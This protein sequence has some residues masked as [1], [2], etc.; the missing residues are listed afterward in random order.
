MMFIKSLLRRFKP[1]VR[2][3]ILALTLGFLVHTLRLNWQQVLT[4]RFTTNAIASLITATGMTLLAHIWSGWVWYWIMQLLNAPVAGA[5]SVITYLKTNLAKYLPGNVWH[6]VG[7]IQFLKSSGTPLAA[8]VTG[9]MLEPLL[10]AAAALAIVVVSLPSTLLQAGILLGVLIGVHPRI[11]NPILKRL[12]APK[13]KQSDLQDSSPIPELSK[14]P[15]KP[16][17]GEILFVLL[18]GIG[19]LL[20]FSALEP[21]AFQDWWVVLGSFSFAWLLGLVVPG[22]PGG[23]GVFEA[24][25]LTLLTPKFSAAVVL[26]TVAIYRLNSTL[27]EALGAG[28]ALIDEKWNLALARRQPVL[29]ESANQRAL[30]GPAS[31]TSI[32]E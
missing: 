11:L 28:L 10:M 30:L 27:A 4:L 26:G 17:L 18:R 1:Y 14:Y 23:L 24:T 25:A 32:Q 22:A 9:V 16:F 31:T 13:L 5:W 20:S 29:P 3:F 12:A 6:F 15:L 21:L 8:A 2:W 7:R 19:F